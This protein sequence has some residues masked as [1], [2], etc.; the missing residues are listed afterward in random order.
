M[1]SIILFFLQFFTL[2]FVLAQSDSY[3]SGMIAMQEGQYRIAESYFHSALQQEPKNLHILNVLASCYTKQKKYAEA[4]SLL[5]LGSEID[6]TFEVL[7]QS[8]AENASRWKKYS[9]AALNYEKHI[10]KCEAKQKTAPMS[11]YHLVMNLTQLL[12][13]EG[14]NEEEKNKI[15][16]YGQKFVDQMPDYP[17]VQ[18]IRKIMLLL[19]DEFPSNLKEGEKWKKE[20]LK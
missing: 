19:R 5:E 11:A 4:D 16:L 7:Y 1:K 2:G 17:Q 12:Y 3:T 15:F 6:S 10:H 13:T 18:D 20:K 9:L 14:I 8:K